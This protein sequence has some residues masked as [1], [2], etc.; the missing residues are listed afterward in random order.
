MQ[1]CLN[2]LWEFTKTKE[3]K[4]NFLQK[5]LKVCKV[6]TVNCLKIP[7]PDIP[8]KKTA[9]NL[10]CRE[11]QK[12]KKELQGVSVSKASAIIWK[13]WKNVKVSKKKMEKYKELYEEEKKRHEEALQRYQDDDADEMEIIKL[14]KKCNKKDKK[15]LQPKALSKSGEPKKVSDDE[16]DPAAK[17]ILMHSTKDEQRPAAKQPKKASSDGKK[18]TKK[19]GKKIKKTSQPKK[20]PKSPE[21]IDS[22]EEEK[23][24][25]PFLGMK[26][27]DQRF[28]DLQK[29]SKN[30][31]IEKKVEKVVFM[32]GPYKGYD[33]S[34]VALYDTKYLKRV[35][36]MSGL[37]K[38]TKDLIKQALAKA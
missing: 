6:F 5:A 2:T 23:E 1:K 20:V 11:I 27:E 3:D 10:F 12:T 21:F 31:K 16:Q 17:C 22:T 32:V 24:E 33:L 29:E 38:K 37:E 13:E 4:K 19:V 7:K 28:F 9:Y 25:P 30:L 36:K 18:T 35:L 14:P 34:Y 8:S 15:V 26:E